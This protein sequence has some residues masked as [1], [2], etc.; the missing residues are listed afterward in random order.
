[1]ANQDILF[2]LLPRNTQ[3]DLR[4]PNLRVH[5]VNKTERAKAVQEEEEFDQTQDARVKDY[6]SNRDK[7]QEQAPQQ[8]NLGE[9]MA[10]EQLPDESPVAEDPRRQ[11]SDHDDDSHKGVYLDTFI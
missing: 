4:D 2:P 3:V 8:G 6:I 5:R 7:Q 9:N 11:H 10:S 1:M